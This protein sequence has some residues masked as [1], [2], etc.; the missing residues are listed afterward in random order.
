MQVARLCTT[1][2]GLFLLPRSQ[3]ERCGVRMAGVVPIWMRISSVN[4]EKPLQFIT[5]GRFGLLSCGWGPK[6]W[7]HLKRAAVSP[8][9]A[10]RPYTAA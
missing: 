1:M 3:A 5:Q 4:L 6:V 2:S 9:A 7:E 8:D 10:P